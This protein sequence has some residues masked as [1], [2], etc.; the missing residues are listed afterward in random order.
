MDMHKSF[1]VNNIKQ[2]DFEYVRFRTYRKAMK[3][4]ALFF[5]LSLSPGFKFYINEQN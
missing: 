2:P 4:S 5:F 1:P 3:F